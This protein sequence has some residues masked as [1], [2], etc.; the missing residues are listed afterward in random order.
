MNATAIETAQAAA[1]PALRRWPARALPLGLVSARVLDVTLAGAVFAAGLAVYCATLAPGLT[2]V[3]LDGNEL[4]TVPHQLGLLHSPGYPFYTWV[5]KLFTYLPL[6]DVAYRMNLMSAVSAAGAATLLYAIVFLLARNRAVALFASL[7]FAF[8]PTLWS[9]AVIT[10]VY[11]P[12]VF[13]M[14]LTLFLF[15]SWG[16]RLRRR[17]VAAGSDRRAAVLFSAA[18]L[19]FGLSLGTHLSNLALAPALAVYVFL[20]SRGAGLSR[21]SF[22]VGGGLFLLA[23]CQ[24]VWL[25][26]RASTLNDELMLRYTP[27]G[28]RGV[29]D[30]MFNVFH[31]DQFAFPLTEVPG[32]IAVYAGLV[33]D[34]FG[35][36]GVGLAL[37]GMWDMRRRCRRAL[38]LLA[39][40]YLAEIA[41]FTQYN[42]TDIAVFFIPA[43]LIFAVFIAFGVRWLGERSLRLVS[44]LQV[45][46]TLVRGCLGLLLVLPVA[47]PLFHNWE[48]NQHSGDTT[49]KDFY[50]RVFRVLPQ[51]S[52]L[53]G[54]PGV[55][56][57]DLFH[58][59]LVYGWRPD[60]AL[61]Q[62]K[63]PDPLTMDDLGERP[64]YVTAGPDVLESE[65][66]LGKD[67][68]L[69][70]DLW[71]VPVLAAPSVYVSW[72][73]GHP[74]TLYEARR[75]PPPFVV[76]T[77][78]P[79]HQVGRV[80]DGVELIGFDLDRTEVAAGG[81]LHITLYWRPLKQPVLNYYRVST[82]LGDGRYRETH[83]LGFGLIRRYQQE[84]RLAPGDVIVED[85]D[86]VVMSSLPKGEHTL[87][88]A[89]CDFGTFGA[90]TEE[91]L[92]LAEIRVVD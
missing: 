75:E 33:G 25:P 47:F 61:P 22:L 34:N 89:T 3:S 77:A 29:Y 1:A 7:L 11:A 85:Y 10:E 91:W 4:A 49:V 26:L 63:S 64:L 36:W 78:A 55:P 48:A 17:S 37:I 2:Y 87:R 40:A 51:G 23:A 15:L 52:L 14:A 50:S 5:G 27:N 83:T 88:L 20:S 18:C 8:S 13:M 72:L 35:L 32:R 42:V 68:P 70:R 16:E 74:L 66:S 80:M 82:I 12:N 24:F 86:L 71:Y 9:Q 67:S 54:R 81:T 46:K 60:V 56:G 41:F 30:Y 28:L 45:G 19:T 44:R 69:L 21:R 58:L 57:F 92:E 31:K 59:P 39:L 53:L 6:G 65:H 62:V 76:Q 90:K 38:C 79:Q 84:R 73:G 43:H